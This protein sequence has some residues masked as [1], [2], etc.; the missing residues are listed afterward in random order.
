MRVLP[1]IVFALIIASVAS[2]AVREKTAMM[3]DRIET[4]ERAAK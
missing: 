4:I 2:T 1:F 3:A